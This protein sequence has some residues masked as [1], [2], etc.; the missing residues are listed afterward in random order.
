MSKQILLIDDDAIT[1]FVNQDLIESSF[2][3]I[4]ITVFYNGADGLKYILDNPEKEFTVFLDLNM[5]IM[6]GWEFLE[7][8][9]PKL[10]EIRVEIHILSS[11]IDPRDRERANKM[12]FVRS[13]VEKPLDRKSLDGLL[14][15][16]IISTETSGGE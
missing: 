2:P 1:N 13:F 8:I 7:G 3:N 9:E 5:P 14:G 11:S 15:N 12:S 10:G 16:K 6:N 4:P